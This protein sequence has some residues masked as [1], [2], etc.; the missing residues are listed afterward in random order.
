[1][2]PCVSVGYPFSPP[3]VF[4]VTMASVAASA[5]SGSVHVSTHP[6]LKH[7]LTLL[8]DKTTD[9]HK[10]RELLKE[11]TFYLGYEATASLTTHPVEVE[12]P[13]GAGTGQ[14]LAERIALVPILRAGLGMVDA[15]LDLVPSAK[16]HHIGMYREKLSLVPIVY[17]NRLPAKVQ[18]DVAVLLEPM[19]ATAGSINAGIEILKA[20]GAPKIKVMALVASKAGL[21]NLRDAHPDV[22]IVVGAVDDA[23]T[24]DGYIVPGLGDVGDRLWGTVDHDKP[25]GKPADTAA[26]DG[27]DRSLKR[28]R[29]E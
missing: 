16:I 24:K 19:I 1:M 29:P 14:K 2:T 27:N 8:R 17:Y 25:A 7:K 28:P 5:S 15:M 23:L 13:V 26:T 18:V 21:Q 20:W 3:K 12:T 9:S 22:E 10:F 4:A 11:I 6:V